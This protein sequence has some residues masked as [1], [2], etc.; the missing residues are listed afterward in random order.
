MT[1]TTQTPNI[2]RY[3]DFQMSELRQME[4]TGNL[5]RIQARA[6][7]WAASVSRSNEDGLANVKAVLIEEARDAY[8]RAKGGSD[9][10]AFNGD[11]F[12]AEAAL[13]E[14]ARKSGRRFV[15]GW[16][17]EAPRQMMFGIWSEIAQRYIRV[18][19]G[20]DA[21]RAQEDADLAEENAADLYQRFLADQE[22]ARVAELDRFDPTANR[23]PAGTY[24]L[25]YQDGSWFTFRVRIVKSGK[26]AGKKAVEFLS[27][28]DNTLDFEMFAFVNEG[29]H[30]T[31]VN[32]WQKY[33]GGDLVNRA[34]E[35][36]STMLKGEAL[37]DA[38]MA[39]ALRSSRCRRCNK[40]L[41][42]PASI[43]RG[44]GPDCA[45]MGG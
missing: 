39:Y 30:R 25:E 9:R 32:V 2:A 33:E 31:T 27:G 36:E 29:A 11:E 6:K 8:R 28:P 42:V 23:L 1:T 40:V 26:L 24:T 37:E 34:R 38:G 45:E 44:M 17:N 13:I 22:A 5:D 14:E 4:A 10:P 7:T 3:F 21:V 18:P 41:T 19:D 43:H 12:D 15:K 35:I 16:T 20:F